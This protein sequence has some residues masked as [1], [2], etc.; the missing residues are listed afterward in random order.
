MEENEFLYKVGDFVKNKILSRE[1][2]LLAIIAI[3]LL[4]NYLKI[5]GSNTICLFAFSVISIIYFFSA[6]SKPDEPGITGI[7][8]FVQKILAWSSSLVILGILFR[9][10]MLKGG[11]NMLVFGTIFLVLSLLYAL[12]QKQTRSDSEVFSKITIYRLVFLIAISIWLMF[13]LQKQ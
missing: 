10:L 5:D 6:F 1:P 11:M 3:C 9:L 8:T 2:I 4:F 12:Y 13:T 7:D